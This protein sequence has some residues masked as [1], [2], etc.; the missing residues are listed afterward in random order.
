MLTT[1]QGKSD[2][3][4]SWE[5]LVG[6]IVLALWFVGSIVYGLVGA[7]M[8]L[9]GKEFKYPIIGDRMKRKA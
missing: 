3:G 7:V 2:W 1:L 9:M 4:L 6:V 5:V 8:V